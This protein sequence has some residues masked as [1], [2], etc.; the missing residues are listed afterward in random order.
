MADPTPPTAASYELQQ[1][2]EIWKAIRE[3]QSPTGTQR[4]LTTLRQPTPVR[5]MSRYTGFGLTAGG[6]LSYAAK[7]ITVPAGKTVAQ[8]TA[9]GHAS[10]LDTVS[11]G[12][13]TTEA[14]IIINGDVSG[15]FPAAKDAGASVVNNVLSATHVAEFAVTPGQ[16]F[17]VSLQLHPLNPSAF[18][19]QPAN[20]AQ[21]V[22]DALFTG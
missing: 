12:V 16:Q 1:I 21:V 22:A 20:F 14:R 13:T 7:T 18:P 4:A 19:P 9:L 3:L 5:A 2:E 17:I 11:G 6:W 8:V 10:A 15:V